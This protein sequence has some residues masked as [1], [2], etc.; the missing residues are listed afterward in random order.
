MDLDSVTIGELGSLGEVVGALATVGTLIYVALQIRENTSWSKRQALESI[1]GNLT[2]WASRLKDN[3]EIVEIYLKGLEDFESLSKSEKLRYHLTLMEVLAAVEIILEHAKSGGIKRESGE[4]AE[5]W[6]YQ[7]L[8]GEGART[9]WRE[10]GRMAF[11]AD[12]RAKVDAVVS[13][14]ESSKAPPNKAM[15]SDT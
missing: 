12:F 3:P 2:S 14:L 10:M 7:E 11:A 8:R 13:E 5:R 9:W 1:V 15:E 4:S 6:I